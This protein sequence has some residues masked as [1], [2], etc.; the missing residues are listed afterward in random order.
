MNKY[1]LIFLTLIS[2]NAYSALTKWVDASGQVHYSDVPPPPN[3]NIKVLSKT[4]S[5][6]DSKS[7]SDPTSSSPPSEPKNIAERELE[8]KKEQQ[9]KKEAA[10]KSAK[11][12]A[13]ADA[14]KAYCSTMQQNLRALQEG[15]RIVEVD[16][17]GN[18]SFVDDEQRQQRIS[19]AQQDISTHCK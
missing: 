6:T 12:Q 13:E 4:Q 19:Q 18:R 9:A 2:A 10:E 15:V 7:A 11:K 3:A 14:K 8:L 17:D 5:T 1:L 16:A